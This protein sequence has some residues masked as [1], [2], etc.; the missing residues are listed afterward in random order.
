MHICGTCEASFDTEEQYVAH[1]CTS[2]F[3]PADPEHLGAEF[4]AIQR[5]ALE[6]G[7][8]RIDPADEAQKADQEDALN[9]LD[10]GGNPMPETPEGSQ[11]ND[12]QDLPIS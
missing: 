12:A 7:L 8:E 9:S 3:T 4:V 2:G 6:R 1:Q 11:S 5:A 10:G